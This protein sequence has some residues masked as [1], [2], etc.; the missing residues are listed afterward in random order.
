VTREIAGRPVE[1]PLA[2]LENAFIEEFLRTRGL[3]RAALALMPAE[4]AAQLSKE[5]SAYAAGR[6]TELESR[7]HYLHELHGASD[8]SKG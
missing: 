4:Q 6:L 2:S 3:D 1:D 8:S 5:A 7:A